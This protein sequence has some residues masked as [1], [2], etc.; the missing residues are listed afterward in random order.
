[1]GFTL[2]DIGF[3]HPG[4]TIF[5]GLNLVLPAGRFTGIVGPNG[6]GKTTLL[7]LICRH[8]KPHAGD[9]RYADKPLADYGRRALARRIA[10][11]HQ[12]YGVNFPFSV[13]A[14]VAMGRYPHTPRFGGLSATTGNGSSGPWPIATCW[15]SRIVP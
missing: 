5:D 10:L 1:M 6:C 3:A 11:V 12:D 9:I 13:E 15:H 4:R 2:S 8:L 14:V 7:D